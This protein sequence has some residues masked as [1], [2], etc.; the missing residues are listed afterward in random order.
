MADTSSYTDTLL[1]LEQL[2]RSEK[3]EEPVPNAKTKKKKNVTIQGDDEDM[4]NLLQQ[5]GED[6]VERWLNGGGGGDL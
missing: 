3:D 5:E 2:V 4:R 1:R 6:R